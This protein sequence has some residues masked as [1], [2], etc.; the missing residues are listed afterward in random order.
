[1]RNGPQRH[2]D[3]E[4]TKIWRSLCLCVSVACGIAAAAQTPERFG[5]GQPAPPELIAALDIDVRPDGTGLPPGRGT[6]REGAQVYARHCAACHG[7]KGEGG[8]ADSLVGPEPKGMAPFGPAYEQ[9]R[10]GRPDVSFTI[11]NYWPYA[12]TIFDYVRR[13][14]PPPAPESL[15]ADETYSV[16]AW[17]L[18]QNGIIGEDTVMSAETLPKVVMPARSRFVRDDRKGGRTIR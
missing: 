4:V 3:T 16:V 11:G 12:T 6:A 17:L 7:A 15:T 10:S 9:W 18:A 1:M 2:R 5:I 8:S 14:M 13:A